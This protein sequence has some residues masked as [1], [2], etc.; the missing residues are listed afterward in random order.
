ME[1]QGQGKNADKQ[2]RNQSLDRQEWTSHSY[3]CKLASLKGFEIQLGE[4]EKKPANNPSGL[5]SNF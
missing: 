1:V 4:T 2:G 3:A 5:Q